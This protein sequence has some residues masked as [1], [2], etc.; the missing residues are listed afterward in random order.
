NPTTFTDPSGHC[1]MEDPDSRDCYFPPPGGDD[2]DDSGS[3]SGGSSGGSG[4]GSGGSSGGSGGYEPPPPPPPPT[5]EEILAMRTGNYNKLAGYMSNHFGGYYSSKSLSKNYIFGSSG[6]SYGFDVK[7]SFGFGKFKFK[8]AKMP[9][10]NFMKQAGSIGLDMIPVVGNIKSGLEAIMGRDLVTGQKLST[11]DRIIAAAGIFTGGAGKVAL[12][13]AKAGLGFAQGAKLAK[14]T[15]NPIVKSRAKIGQEA[16]RQ[17]EAE[18]IDKWIPEQTITLPNGKVVRKD[19]V[20]RTNPNLVRI[21][22]PDTPSGI[23][24]ANKR[25]KLM[26]D[27]GYETQIDL[28]NP[29]DARF[30]PGSPTYIGPRLK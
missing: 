10:T 14:G 9:S 5:F 26:R 7:S 15:N 25:A 21:I 18:G 16:H 13:G 1:I 22:K 6:S 28:Y 27:F 12:K 8:K 20:S 30:Q 11:A 19:G 4:S 23:R 3:G 2:D 17:L 29:L 24:S